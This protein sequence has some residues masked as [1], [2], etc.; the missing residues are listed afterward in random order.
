M[1]LDV[2]AGEYRVMYKDKWISIPID[3]LHFYFDYKGN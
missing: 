1:P 2:E 3:V